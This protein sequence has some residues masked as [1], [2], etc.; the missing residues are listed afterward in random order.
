MYKKE[1]R[2]KKNGINKERLVAKGY[3]MTR[4]LY[5]DDTEER[6]KK[7]RRVEFMILSIDS[8]SN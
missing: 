2:M 6:R 1:G 3:G 7:N 4:R 5:P 8:P